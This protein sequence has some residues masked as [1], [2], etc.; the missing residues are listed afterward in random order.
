MRI[1]NFLIGFFLIGLLG[2]SG[3]ENIVDNSGSSNLGTNTG[4]NNS[5][6]NDNIINS[7]SVNSIN[8]IWELSES[9][10]SFASLA[11]INIDEWSLLAVENTSLNSGEIFVC[12]GGVSV[13]KVIRSGST[14]TILS[15]AELADLGLSVTVNGSR[16]EV[17]VPPF[18][19]LDAKK[20]STQNLFSLEVAETT[21]PSVLNSQS[22][23]GHIITNSETGFARIFTAATFD[24]ALIIT[25][26]DYPLGLK[27]Q[28]DLGMNE[29]LL[30]M[31]SNDFTSY[32]G[33]NGLIPQL[34]TVT[35][36]QCSASK[37]S[38]VINAELSDG[39]KINSTQIFNHQN[40]N[41]ACP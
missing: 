23:C 29:G 20:V 10:R 36:T 16:A 41:I 26:F 33:A 7:N 1:Q 6:N 30:T 38:I 22:L 14:Y 39:T 13:G 25:Q 24:K 28:L 12:Q 40:S 2:C 21:L 35:I 5:L 17:D 8:G 18:S 15:P 37:L 9:S 31:V 27:F 4:I 34:G 32:F 19:G 11:G 3:E